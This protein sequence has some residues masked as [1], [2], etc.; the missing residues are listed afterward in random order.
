LLV[1]ELDVAE[2]RGVRRLSKPLELAR[3]SVLVGRNNAG[4]TAVLE[5]LYM[6]AMPFPRA[7][8]PYGREPVRL[9]SE[10]HGGSQSCRGSGA[11]PLRPRRPRDA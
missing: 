10:L 3:F 1:R 8:P 6:L 4:K 11:G 7:L 5:A 2:F 9:V